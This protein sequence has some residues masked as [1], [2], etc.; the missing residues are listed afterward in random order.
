[1]GEASRT[2]HENDIGEML[3]K[4]QN[5]IRAITQFDLNIKQSTDQTFVCLSGQ[6]ISNNVTQIDFQNDT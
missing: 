3:D 2:V 1:M 5:E 6:I 4:N